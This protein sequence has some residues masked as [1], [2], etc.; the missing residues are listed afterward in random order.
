MHNDPATMANVASQNTIVD[1][2]VGQVMAALRKKGLDKNTLV[3]FSSD[4]GNFYGQHGLW[5][6]T[7]VTLPSNLYEAAL[8]IPLIVRQPG[9]IK[10]GVKNDN[11]IGQYDIPVTILDYLGIGDVQFDGGPGRSFVGILRNKPTA[12]KNEVYYEQEESRG[13][14]TPEYAYWKRLK[15]TGKNELYDM[16]SDPGQHHNLYT[17]LAYKPVIAELDNKLADFFAEYSSKQYD[18]WQGGVAKGSVVRPEMFRKLY[19]PQWRPKTE[20]IAAFEE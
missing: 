9:A 2:G 16:Q 20:M 3:I 13:V 17:D 8:N 11:L 19:G 12:W 18:L 1:D 6:H 14:R 10:A 5:Q 7:V 15:T 4:Q